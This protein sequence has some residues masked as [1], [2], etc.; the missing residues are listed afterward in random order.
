MYKISGLLFSLWR[1]NVALALDEP[2]KSV[3][4]QDAIVDVFEEIYLTY[5]SQLPMV[6]DVRTSS[7]LMSD[8]AKHC[9]NR[10]NISNRLNFEFKTRGNHKYLLMIFRIIVSNIPENYKNISCEVVQKN[11]SAETLEL[12][13]DM[14]LKSNQF[15]T[16]HKNKLKVSCELLN[17]MGKFYSMSVS[18]EY[19]GD[20]LDCIRVIWQ[21]NKA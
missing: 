9:D 4:S 21:V 16:S 8:I 15:N 3:R 20:E 1:K 14:S 10:L 6:M 13:F 7:N 11:Q 2:I 19:A 5:L 18:P 12:M 17:K